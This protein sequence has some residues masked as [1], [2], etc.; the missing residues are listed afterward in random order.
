MKKTL[1]ATILLLL[2]PLASRAQHFEWA[3]GYGQGLEG[4]EII[5]SVTDSLGNL[6]I[7]GYFHTDIDHQCRWDGNNGPRLLP[8]AT[9]QGWTWT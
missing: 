4:Q 8:I 9:D 6:Y 2:L 5:G 1:F 7:L 3:K